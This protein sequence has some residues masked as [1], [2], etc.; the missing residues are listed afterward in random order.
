MLSTYYPVTIASGKVRTQRPFYYMIVGLDE[1]TNCISKIKI[2]HFE[3]KK[4]GGK[5]YFRLSDNLSRISFHFYV[6]KIFIILI[7]YSKYFN[8]RP[9]LDDW[10]RFE[11]RGGREER[12]TWV[13]T[14]FVSSHTD[15]CLSF[16]KLWP[17]GLKKVAQ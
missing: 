6:Q 10:S 13:S 4:E 17:D 5:L 3:C 8:F 7:F 1:V 11:A 16:F 2:W 12:P 9:R 15:D 14:S